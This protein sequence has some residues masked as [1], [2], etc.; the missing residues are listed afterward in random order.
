MGNSNLTWEKTSSFNLGLDFGFL[1]GRI[2]GSID[3]Y[4]N[5]TYDLLFY[6]T[7]PASSF[8]NIIDNIGKTKG[9]G[10]EVSLTTDIVRTKDFDWTANWSYSHFK[11][12]I[13]ELTGGV[14][15]YV[16]G[17]NGLFVG[18]RVNAFYD[19]RVD[20]EWGIGEFDQYVEAYKARHD[21]NAPKFASGYGTPGSPKICDSNDNGTIDSE[22][23]VLYNK[24]PNHV[25]GMNNTFTY[26]DFSLSVQLM[27]RLGGYIAYDMN[28]QL[29]Y[30]SANW[31]DIDY[32]TPSNQG[33]K[34][35]NPGLSD[36]KLYSA[37]TS[38]FLYEKADYLKIKDITLSYNVPAK[39]LH[40]IGMSSAR[41]YCS[42]KNFI[43]WSKIDNY[44]PERGGSIAFP[45]Q[46]Q[47]V[48]GF[49]VVF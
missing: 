2:S 33:A 22:D 42:M 16:S 13:T 35:P 49:N 15:K 6:K 25:F 1:N 28:K 40:T 17:T 24:D 37:Y 4:W 32:W 3:Y 7:G 29:N 39:W 48:L 34:F 12:E 47:V 5:K 26:K 45:M 21:G 43:T 31:G 46:K 27:A 20:G 44:D 10:L 9:Q 38:A 18:N 8:P 19:Y 41:V 11:D 30:E 23:R 36:N 14:N